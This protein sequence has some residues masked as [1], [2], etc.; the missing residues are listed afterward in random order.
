MRAS[1]FQREGFFD[2]LR[3]EGFQGGIA[4]FF[5]KLLGSGFGGHFAIVTYSRNSPSPRYAELQALYRA[6]H[7]KGETFLGIPPENTF[8]G[9][10]LPPQAGRIK[11]LIDADRRARRPRLRLRQGPAVRAARDR[12]TRRAASGPAYIDYW[13]VDEVVCYDPAYAPFSKFPDGRF[14]G[15]ISTDVLEHCP[16]DDMRWIVEEIFGFAERFVFANVACYPARKRLP[17]GENAHCTVKPD[18]WW[19]EIFESVAARHAGLLWEVWVDS[20][21]ETLEG[22]QHVES[23]MGN[24]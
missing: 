21:V 1:R 16:E 22:Q 3:F 10:S 19:R 7:E 5:N 24:T 18:A 2:S 12:R 20:R 14:D 11:Q 13:D 6:M 4:P 9:T 15:V 8:P 23:R 17:T